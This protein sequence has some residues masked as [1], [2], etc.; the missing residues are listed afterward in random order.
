MYCVYSKHL[1]SIGI[2]H[3]N[4]NLNWS[5]FP[6]PLT[7]LPIGSLCVDIALNESR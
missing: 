6:S 5:T 2:E 4:S 3:C 7:H 1:G